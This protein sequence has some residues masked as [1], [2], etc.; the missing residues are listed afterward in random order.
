MKERYWY[1]KLLPEALET[2][3]ITVEPDNLDFYYYEKNMLPMQ[4]YILLIENIDYFISRNLRKSVFGIRIP[5]Q[6]KISVSDVIKLLTKFPFTSLELLKD[7]RYSEEDFESLATLTQIRYLTLN[8]LS[9]NKYFNDIKLPP[10]L[11]TLNFIS[12]NAR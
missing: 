12:F 11:K 8:L 1:E 2:K 10:Y 4:R 6:T 9:T 7:Y 3:V 5:K